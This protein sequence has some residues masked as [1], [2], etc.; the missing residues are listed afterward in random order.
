MFGAQQQ[1]AHQL[2]A[3][4]PAPYQGFGIGAQGFGGGGF[5]G[6]GGYSYSGGMTNGYGGG[7]AMG[8]AGVSMIGGVGNAFF[9]S[10]GTMGAVGGGLMGGWKGAALGGGMGAAVGMAGKHVFGSMMEGAH[11]QA[12]LERTMSQFQFQNANSRT[13]KGFSRSDAMQIGNMVRQMERVPEMLTSFGELNKLMDKMGQ[14]GLMQGVRDA[15]QFMDKFRSTVNT[16]KDLS[17]LIGTTMEGALQAFGEARMSGFYTQ[18]DIVKNVINRQITGSMTGMNQGQVGALQQFGAQIGHATGGTRASGAKHVLRTAGQL[19][20]MNQMGILTNDQIMEMTGK[21]GSEGIQDLSARMTQLGYRMAKSNVGQAMTLAMM[22]VGEDGR[23]TGN[24]D[25]DL[26]RRFRSGEVGLG[27]L[28]QMARKKAHGRGRK[29][30]FSYM[31]RNGRLTSEM[32]GQ[33]GAEGMGLMLKSILGD[34]GWSNPDAIGLVTERFGA[35]YEEA[36]L[37]KK[38]YSN[39]DQIG[40][41]MKAEGS[42]MMRSQARQALM[43]ERFSA[44]AVKHKIFKKIEHVVT[45]PFKDAGVA[46]RNHIAGMYED[47]MD[48]LTGEYTRTLTKGTADLVRNSMIGNGA[49]RTKLSAMIGSAQGSSAFNRGAHLGNTYGGAT[50]L[51]G[52]T[53]GILHGLG[54]GD[55][56]GDRLKKALLVMGGSDAVDSQGWRG[57]RKEDIMDSG[58]IVLGES[59][60]GVTGSTS[61]ADINAAKTIGTSGFRDTKGRQAWRSRWAGTE[62]YQK[63]IE[64]LQNAMAGGRFSGSD[65]QQMGQMNDV[66]RKAVGK[67]TFEQMGFAKGGAGALSQFMGSDEMKGYYG[68]QGLEGK[69]G[70]L[71]E[72]F[73][74]KDQK[75]VAKALADTRK[76]IASK[77]KQGDDKESFANIDKMLQGDPTMRNLLLGGD[78]VRGLIDTAGVG[79]GTLGEAFLKSSKDGVAGLAL[80]HALVKDPGHWSP[81]EEAAA[82]KVGITKEYARQNRD[83]LRKVKASIDAQDGDVLK[84]LKNM[85]KL[86]G[87]GDMLELER[88]FKE[89]G[90]RMKDAMGNF[91][92]T[93][94]G[95][96]AKGQAA[97]KTLAA[98][99]EALSNG[100]GMAMAGQSTDDKDP[101]APSV[102]GKNFSDLASQISD[103]PEA[104]KKKF[105]AM[106]SEG[107]GSFAAIQ[108][109]VGTNDS[110]MRKGRNLRAGKEGTGKNL[111]KFLGED[112]FGQKDDAEEMWK[113]LE[114]KFGKTVEK[115]DLAGLAKAVST[116][117]GADLMARAG[118]ERTSAYVTEQDIANSLLEMSKNT[119]QA[120]EILK[121]LVPAAGTST[122]NSSPAQ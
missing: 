80:R 17:K 39:L 14:M 112:R 58:R 40:I 50:R 34:R 77:F 23:L 79:S 56:A 33:M 100:E 13:G 92:T 16:L 47:Y 4:M 35:S 3:G 37:L 90:G 104:E 12:A 2:S 110:I 98:L 118:G 81:E 108:A 54:G 109:M 63:G 52:V 24:M 105:M 44:D 116:G 106:L 95:M 55:L 66:L 6:G 84:G 9:G 59:Y 86:M 94:G 43:R 107:G 10:M 115:G 122:P 48:E 5:S 21:E 113:M 114:D 11:E 38:T 42:G 57:E 22:E 102:L 64:A 93:I 121:T 117:K 101:N 119:K 75:G 76:S 68:A 111:R 19:G 83:K 30:Q 103:L 20:M 51:A 91:K 70:K 60:T 27:E 49:A 45:D 8:N 73:D 96:G 85:S 65:L 87:T 88:Q 74:V 18:G 7:N 72:G 29:I 61:M 25:E 71:L 31:N 82:A 46:V 120:A 41:N 36:E 26:V 53:R 69:W 1:Y 89:T 62:S 99:S 78:G 28:K 32:A 15:G 97:A 67:E